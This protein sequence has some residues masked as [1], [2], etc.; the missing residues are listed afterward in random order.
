MTTSF[1]HNPVY[2]NPM[3]RIIRAIGGR[4]RD[5]KHSFRMNW[6]ELNFGKGGFALSLHLF[7]DPPHFSFQI[8]A[9]WVNLYVKLPFL[10]RFAYEPDEMMDSWGFSYGTDG[11]LF[12]RWGSKCKIVT[13]PWH[14]W[15]QVS[16]DIR[17]SAGWAPYVGSWEHDKKPDGRQIEKF[18]YRYLLR[19]GEKQEV[20]ASVHVERRVRRLRWLRWTS[21]FQHVT[22]AIDVEFSDEVGEG[23]G[24]W[25]GGTVGCAYEL[26]PEET[27]RQCLQR[28]ESE[29]RF[30]R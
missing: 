27:P 5:G 3:P 15:Q 13:M 20:T 2:D 6:G 11:A 4:F 23:A 17:T 8:F 1:S 24:S 14:D 19:S 7:D 22:Y 9:L 29:R 21:V 12:L 18:P 30:G 26:R 16:H 25:K 10:R 28:M